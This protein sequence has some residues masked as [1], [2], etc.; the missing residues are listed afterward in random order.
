MVMRRL[1][2][3]NG[4]FE[5]SRAPLQY[6]VAEPYGLSELVKERAVSSK[7]GATSLLLT[8][9]EQC[10]PIQY[11]LASLLGTPSVAEAA[12]EGPCVEWLQSPLGACCESRG[13]LLCPQGAGVDG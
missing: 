12:T 2:L 10:S 11:C 3:L 9:L 7:R 8:Y 5:S 6:W 4:Q 13:A 1:L